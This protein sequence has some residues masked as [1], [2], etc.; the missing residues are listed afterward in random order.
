M[1]RALITFDPSISNTTTTAA[2]T[3][4]TAAA[5]SEKRIPISKS[6]L[7]TAHRM[8]KSKEQNKPFKVSFAG[9]SATTGR[10]N[11]FDESFTSVLAGVDSMKGTNALYS[12][13]NLIKSSRLIDNSTEISD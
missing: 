2:A 9:S 6:I 13:H 8:I 11:Y 5:D 7:Y 1:R 3:T 4:T 10:G 12:L